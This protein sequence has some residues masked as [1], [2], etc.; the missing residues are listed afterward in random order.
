MSDSAKGI[1]NNPNI[2]DYQPGATAAAL[3][4][5]RAACESGSDTS[6]L[7]ILEWISKDDNLKNLRDKIMD[8]AKIPENN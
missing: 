7:A 4:L 1:M 5:V 6:K 8:A 3:E 2:L